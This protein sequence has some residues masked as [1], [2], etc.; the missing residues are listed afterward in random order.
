[1]RIMSLA[2][3]AVACAGPVLAGDARPKPADKPPLLDLKGKLTAKDPLDKLR[4]DSY[5]KVHTLK[6]KAG[7]AY[8]IDL[9]SDDFDAYLR[10]EDSQGKSL[11]EDDDGGG[12]TDARLVFIPPKEDDYR[13]IVTTFAKGDTG[14]YALTVRPVTLALAVK[15]KLGPEDKGDPKIRKDC[16]QK[17][18]VLKMAPGRIYT[19]TL[20]SADFDAYLFLQDSQGKVLAEDDD[21]GGGL[22]ARILFTP[23][24][25]DIYRI[26]VTTFDEK[27]TGAY[28]LT[29]I[30]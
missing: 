29:V 18:H 16:F 20:Q 8:Q 13:I 26:I 4:P 1:M 28:T 11:A 15:D 12:G 5:H 3:L 24:R 7:R 23:T 25:E 22:N 9:R 14:S 19:I 17:A 27:E 6:L 21:S 10:L 30:E 2:I